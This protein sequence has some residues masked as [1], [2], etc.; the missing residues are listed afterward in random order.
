MYNNILH[1]NQIYTILY[2]YEYAPINNAIVHY[3]DQ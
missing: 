3:K 1:E 2:D